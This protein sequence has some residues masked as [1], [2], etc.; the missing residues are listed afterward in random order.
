[1]GLDVMTA[2]AMVQPRAELP[3]TVKALLGQDGLLLLLMKQN[4]VWD[5]AGG[6]V[7]GSESLDVALQREVQEETGLLV[8]HVSPFSQGLRHREPRVPVLVT[9]YDV[10]ISRPWTTGDVRLSTEHRDMVMADADLLMRLPMPE[11]Y[12]QMGLTWL[13]RAA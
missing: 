1:M 2:A 10:L 8:R 4:G 13:Q 7:D 12:K 3:Q 6:K 9:F 11:V 5:L